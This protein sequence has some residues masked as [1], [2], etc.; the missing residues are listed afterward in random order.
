MSLI[1]VKFAI[2]FLQYP[3][4]TVMFCEK[5]HFKYLIGTEDIWYV[6]SDRRLRVVGSLELYVDAHT[7]RLVLLFDVNLMSTLFIYG[8]PYWIN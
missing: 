8:Y 5:V 4:V 6:D 2:D 7:L 1:V 3:Q